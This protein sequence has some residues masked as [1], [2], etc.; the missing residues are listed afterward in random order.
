MIYF[1]NVKPFGLSIIHDGNHI[2]A[3]LQLLN[4]EMNCSFRGTSENYAYFSSVRDKIIRFFKATFFRD[5]INFEK[6]QEISTSECLVFT[7]QPYY[8]IEKSVLEWYIF[9]YDE[10][11]AEKGGDKFDLAVDNYSKFDR[12]LHRGVLYLIRCAPIAKITN[13]NNKVAT[14]EGPL[15]HYKAISVFTPPVSFDLHSEFRREC[16]N[17]TRYTYPTL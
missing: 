5:K 17:Y 15:L 10:Q 14:V 9:N 7:R 4:E 12:Y 16:V 13:I 8:Y 6:L 3:D 1:N 11:I 2:N